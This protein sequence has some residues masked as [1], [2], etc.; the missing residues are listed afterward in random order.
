MIIAFN[1]EK[2]LVWIFS[3]IVKTDGSFAALIISLSSS[4]C[5]LEIFA[6]QVATFSSR[7]QA[8]R[9]LFELCFI[10]NCF[11][12][13]F[14]PPALPAPTRPAARCIEILRM[15]EAGFYKYVQTKMQISDL[16]ND[17]GIVELFNFNINVCQQGS[18]KL[19]VHHYYS[20]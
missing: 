3:V 2:A 13:Q 19:P 5:M 6:K 4:C 17:P 10:D 11:P 7:Q 20:S 16:Y 1:K 12:P 9:V 8:G 18:L 15:K 14:P